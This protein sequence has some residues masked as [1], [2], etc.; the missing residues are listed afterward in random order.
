[1]NALSLSMF[2]LVGVLL[3]GCALPKPHIARSRSYENFVKVASS[4]PQ[5]QWAYCGSDS[6]HHHFA[7]WRYGAMLGAIGQ[8]SYLKRHRVP[9]DEMNVSNEFFRT[10]DMEEW[11][12]YSLMGG[13]SDG[14]FSRDFLRDGDTIPNAMR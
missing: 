10:R 11:R 3:S 1:M 2:V 8:S 13:D 14:D 5:Y 9:R 12:T 4:P 7:Q 6:R